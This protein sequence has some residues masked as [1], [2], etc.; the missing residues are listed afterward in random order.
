MNQNI[1]SIKELGKII[2]K[3]RKSQKLTQLDVS[4]ISSLGVRFISEVE[5]GKETSQIG[6]VLHL[7][8]TLGLA[9]SIN[10]T[11]MDDLD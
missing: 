4:G 11:W 7:A 5:N 10:C 1:S 2:K 3:V 9:L 8:N 6:K